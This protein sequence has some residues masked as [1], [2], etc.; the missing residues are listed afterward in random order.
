LQFYSRP[1]G[2]QR[3]LSPRCHVSCL[4]HL[5]GMC[6]HFCRDSYQLFQHRLTHSMHPLDLSSHPLCFQDRSC[7]LH[8]NTCQYNHVHKHVC[9]HAS[10]TTRGLDW[11]STSTVYTPIPII[12][13]PFPMCDDSA[14]MYCKPYCKLTPSEEPLTDLPA[15]LPIP[16]DRPDRPAGGIIRRCERLT[17]VAGIGRNLPQ[18]SSSIRYIVTYTRIISKDRGNT[19]KLLPR[20]CPPLF[21]IFTDPFHWLVVHHLAL[22]TE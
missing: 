13:T 15:T 22:T 17:T 5:V 9:A 8:T 7:C 4:Q 16:R 20:V 18:G 2:C 21:S 19:K 14:A 11:T 12:Y 10:T 3:C 6:L 1:R